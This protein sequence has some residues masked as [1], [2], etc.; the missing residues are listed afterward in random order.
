MSIGCMIPLGAGFCVEAALQGGYR[1]IFG[2][3][4]Y[5]YDKA[6]DK[7]YQESLFG[8]TGMVIG[9]RLSIVYRIGIH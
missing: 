3:E 7:N 9:F 6:D 2:G 1:S 4:K 8:A 5:R